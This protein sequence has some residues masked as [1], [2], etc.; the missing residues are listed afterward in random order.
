MT[1]SN[2]RPAFREQLRKWIGAI[3]R[4]WADF[5]TIFLDPFVVVFLAVSISLLYLVT[6][7][8]DQ[9]IVVTLSAMSGLAASIVGAR[10]D[11]HWTALTEETLIQTRGKTAIR[12]LKDLFR[13][14]VALRERTNA[15]LLALSTDD[16]DEKVLLALT[17]GN[18]EEVRDR[19]GLL[20]AQV[21]SSI[22]NW[23]DVVPEV[24][25]VIDEYQ[26]AQRNAQQAA[27]Q[28]VTLQRNLDEA[29]KQQNRSE[30]EIAA[31][32]QQRDQAQRSL[33]DQQN[34]V[35]DGS[36]SLGASLGGTAQP[37]AIL[38]S[39]NSVVFVEG[40]GK[41]SDLGSLDPKTPVRIVT[42]KVDDE[43]KSNK[44]IK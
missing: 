23:T 3:V 19:C 22:E 2:I 18:W 29:V 17:R 33:Q 38:L 9:W 1:T 14:A 42:S 13:H 35:R 5:L 34:R 36:F 7:T 6:R 28:L 21:L 37:D 40:K 25:T 10:V 4:K 30:A 31:L 24:Q 16:L 12:G 27:R 39:G 26:R 41:L 43:N 15:H 20:E 8:T 32:R 44:I 11:R